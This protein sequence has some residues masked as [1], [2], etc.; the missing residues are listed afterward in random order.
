MNR[1]NDPKT[2]GSKKLLIWIIPEWNSLKN[3]ITQIIDPLVALFILVIAC[4]TFRRN[5]SCNR[6]KSRCRAILIVEIPTHCALDTLFK[7]QRR[8]PTK[9]ALG[10]RESMA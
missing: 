8:F 6:P 2:V 3:V 9:F 7:L 10:L 4:Y 1:K 5:I